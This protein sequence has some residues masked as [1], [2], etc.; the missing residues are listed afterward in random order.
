VCNRYELHCQ[1][2]VQFQQLIELGWI[3][4]FINFNVCPTQQVPV[5]PHR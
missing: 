5:A 3:L 1:Q 2:D 4:P